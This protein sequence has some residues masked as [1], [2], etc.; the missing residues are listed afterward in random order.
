MALLVIIL[1]MTSGDEVIVLAI[2]LTAAMF[3]HMYQHLDTQL[4]IAQQ[5]C[6][7]KSL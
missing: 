6:K 2:I 7:C 4:P 1:P 5:E 3:Y